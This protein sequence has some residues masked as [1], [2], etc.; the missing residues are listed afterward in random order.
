MMIVPV[1]LEGPEGKI[2]THAFL[3]SGSTVTI[4]RDDL[5]RRLRLQGYSD[6]LCSKW[7]NRMTYE[8]KTS[9]RVSVT[10]TGDSESYKLKDI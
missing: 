10:I 1:T 6:P 3:D 7:M 9:R 5:A 4:I 2:E 8:D